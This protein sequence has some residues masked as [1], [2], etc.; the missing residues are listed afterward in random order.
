MLRVI[1]RVSSEEALH[2]G[3]PRADGRKILR[4][5]IRVLYSEAETVIQTVIWRTVTTGWDT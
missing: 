5:A 2:L 4:K 1:S 3:T